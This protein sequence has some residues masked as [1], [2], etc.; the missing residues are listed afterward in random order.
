MT[1][2][3][4]ETPTLD[5]VRRARERIRDHVRL[6]PLI[7]AMPAKAPI[8][9]TGRLSLKLEC[10]QI[11][12]S[13][14]ARGA[15]AKLT[16]LEAAAVSRGLVT[17]SG[18]NHGRGVAY[19]GWRAGAPAKIFL[20]RSTPPAKAEKIAAWGAEVVHHG[21]V[22]DE[23]NDAALAAAEAEGLTYVHPF[24]DPAV[25]AGQGTVALEI[26][27]QAADADVLLV[28]IGGGGLI[29][30]VATA[31][32]ALKPEIEI[33]GIEAAGAPTLKRSLEAGQLVT[34]DEILTE[35]GTLAP[36]RSAAI[37]LRII[38][39]QVSEIVLVTD[40][41]MRQ[42]AGWLWFEFGIAAEL[43]GAAAVAAL[44]AGAY[45]PAEGAHVVAL[46]C[47]AGTDGIV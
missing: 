11:V 30:G 5:D 24:A 37:N 23:A 32:K 46:V 47:G 25:I 39:E 1:V 34:L 15:S 19:A 43:S 38:S 42:A 44:Q 41:E 4:D 22:W 8:H 28:A 36:R 9:A 45:R 10:L 21:A 35:A 2:A 3:T 12:G 13:F 7:P 33:I 6:T 29:S 16:S 27:E 26:L 20:P 40:E 18:G 17:A 31:A 14:K